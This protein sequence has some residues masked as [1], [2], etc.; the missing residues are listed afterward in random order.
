MRNIFLCLFCLFVTLSN[1]T[2][3]KASGY[4][5]KVDINTVKTVLVRNKDKLL[6]TPEAF[7][8]GL[9]TGRKS[10]GSNVTDV[11][12]YRVF[13]ICLGMPLFNDLGL[14]RDFVFDVA[15]AYNQKVDEEHQK[16]IQGDLKPAEIL[17]YTASERMFYAAKLTNG[18][19]AVYKTKT[20][21]EPEEFQCIL[22]GSDN[23][24]FG[25]SGGA[26]QWG[27][28]GDA[29]MQCIN[30]Y[31]IDLPKNKKIWKFVFTQNKSGGDKLVAYPYDSV[32]DYAPSFKWFNGVSVGAEALANAGAKV[33]ISDLPKYRIWVSTSNLQ[34]RELVSEPKKADWDD[35]C[36][37]R[38]G[39]DG[40]KGR[41]NEKTYTGRQ[42]INSKVVR[43]ALVNSSDGGYGDVNKIITLNHGKLGGNNLIGTLMYDNSK[44]D[45]KIEWK[46]FEYTNPVAAKNAAAKFA[47]SL[48]E[49]TVKQL[50]ACDNLY[51]YVV[52]QES[53]GG[54]RV[55]Y[56]PK[57]D[58]AT[59]YTI[60][61]E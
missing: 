57:V 35:R 55:I 22:E 45:G 39:F 36:A 15:L 60:S 30:R 5:T 49:A 9:N 20:K 7:I 61:Y 56:A 38:T 33:A 8:N 46:S 59:N 18:Q 32:K 53:K 19:I 29:A 13:D 42:A 10:D 6:Q 43:E 11:E 21:K 1:V 23:T 48:R 58:A 51:V 41:N 17:T 4:T 54:Y 37:E 14:C 3:A 25:D 28:Y 12:I 16:A 47:R 27:W 26:V 40:L 2:G 24:N 52:Q 44:E 50:H 34:S 31:T